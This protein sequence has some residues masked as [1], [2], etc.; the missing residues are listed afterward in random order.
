MKRES[1]GQRVKTFKAYIPQS[2]LTK[3]ETQVVVYFKADNG[4]FY[5]FDGAH[6]F[7]PS[8]DAA[9]KSF[10]SR[11]LS[12][13]ENMITS[14]TLGRIVQGFED[15]C[16][17]YDNMMRDAAKKK[18]IRFSFKANAPWYKDGE[19]AMK[20]ISF[21]DTPALH[22]QYEVLYRVGDNLYAPF[23]EEGA[24]NLQYRGRYDEARG[25][26]GDATT[27]DWT[28]EREAFFAN[29]QSSLIEMIRRVNDFNKNLLVNVDNAIA[30]NAP[31]LLTH[32]DHGYGDPT[33]NQ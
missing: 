11:E 33:D 21:C 23:G 17:I 3:I 27:I 7:R 15:I 24:G 29:M 13:H 5:I 22:I 18:V 1:K 2:D 20:D 30:A 28:E 4:L 16:T 6:M 31:L 10:D 25:R 26:S 12:I 9:Q 8:S 32:K 14:K 19:A